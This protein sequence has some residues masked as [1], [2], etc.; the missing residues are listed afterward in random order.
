[1]WTS[2][3]SKFS[4][5]VIP[6]KNSSA[7][8]TPKINKAHLSVCCGVLRITAPTSCNVEGAS[9]ERVEGLPCSLP[10][11]S[12]NGYLAVGIPSPLTYSRQLEGAGPTCPVKSEACRA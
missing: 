7:V 3:L 5:S 10:E 2:K 4:C 8:D 6:S 1:M 11:L 9:G 12:L